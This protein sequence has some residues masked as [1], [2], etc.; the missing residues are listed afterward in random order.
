M[1]DVVMD[2]VKYRVSKA[3]SFEWRR[4]MKYFWDKDEEKMEVRMASI[5]V[6][7]SNEYLGNTSRLVVTPLTVRFT[8]V[9]FQ[10]CFV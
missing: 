8:L 1:R 7:Y 10:M 9:F 3:D 2:L 5:I 4:Q 6:N